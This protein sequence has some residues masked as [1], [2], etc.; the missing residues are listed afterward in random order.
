M[1]NK[2]GTKIW[3]DIYSKPI[4][5]KQ[6]VPFTSN[7]QRH[8]LTNIP[9]SLARRTCAIV[10]NQKCKRKLI[11]KTFFLFKFLFL[12]LSNLKTQLLNSKIYKFFTTNK[13]EYFKK[14]KK[15]KKEK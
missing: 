1:I 6:Y 13:N 4:D 14:R 9:F 11:L 15:K 7:H 3:M 2:N 5:S 8:C 12:F 10:E